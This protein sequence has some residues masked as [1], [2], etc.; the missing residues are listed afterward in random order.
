ARG[1]AAPGGWGRS[2][3]LGAG[4]A[5]AGLREPAD[6]V[7]VNPPRKGLSEETRAAILGARPA[8]LVYVSCGPRALG[9]DLAAL[10]AAYEIASVHP[11]DLMPGTPQVETVVSLRSRGS[12]RP[13]RGGR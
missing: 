8:Q 1:G 12:A 4:D 10:A 2:A 3:R 7:V 9:L 6:V 11:F 5:A 13:G